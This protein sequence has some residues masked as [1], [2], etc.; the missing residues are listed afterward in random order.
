LT[1][2]KFLTKKSHGKGW[3]MSTTKSEISENFDLDFG[4]TG[5][6]KGNEYQK[7]MKLP[8][9]GSLDPSEGKIEEKLKKVLNIKT[10]DT[11]VMQLLRPEVKDRSILSPVNFREKVREIRTMVNNQAGKKHEIGG[12]LLE[13]IDSLL[14]EEEEKSE[15]LDQ[16]RHMLLLG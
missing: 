12:E 8:I 15:L 3:K 7:R 1:K 13:R 10:V 6:T 11:L 16:Y 5:I 14:K 4:I 9:S 2:S